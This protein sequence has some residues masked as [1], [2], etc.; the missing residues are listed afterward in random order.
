MKFVFVESRIAKMSIIQ[1]RVF[2][3]RFRNIACEGL[4]PDPFWNPH[5]PD[6]CIE[7]FFQMAFVELNLAN[8]IASWDCGQDRFVV[9]AAEQ[10]NLAAVDKVSDLSNVFGMVFRQPV[11][12]T[13]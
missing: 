11:E 13:P 9:G 1:Q 6:T 5:P 2:D 8:A 7:E 10:F 12:Q 3:S 4:F